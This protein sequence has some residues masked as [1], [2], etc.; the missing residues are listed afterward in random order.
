MSLVPMSR[1]ANGLGSNGN[2]INVQL[3]LFQVSM[4]PSKE[5]FH[6]NVEIFSSKDTSP[7]IAMKKRIFNYI[8]SKF[9]EALD[10]IGPIFD[11]DK[12]VYSHRELQSLE[13]T[14]KVPSFKL[15][16]EDEEFKYILSPVEKPK[17]RTSDIFHLLFGP[18][19]PSMR[20]KSDDE[21]GAL[22]NS[23][24]RAM[25]ALNVAVRYLLASNCPSTSR[26]FFPDGAPFLDIGTGVILRR[27][28]ITHM[29]MGNTTNFNPPPD[30]LFLAM[31]M[32]CATFL[33]A[34]P[35]NNPANT[36]AD[37]CCKI[38]NIPPQRMCNLQ[39]DDYRKLHK[40]LRRFKIDIVRGESDRGI[41]KSI[42]HLT[43][44]NSR[45]EIF[46]TDEGETSVEAFFLKT[47]G[48]RLRFPDLPNVVTVGKGKKTVY[49]M[50]LCSIRKGQRYILKLNG[51]QQSSALRFQTIKP[52]GRF[53]QIMVARE[54]V[55]DHTHEKLLSAYGIKIGRKFVEAQ[56]RVLPPPV[57]EYSQNLR[58]SVR[59]GQWNIAKP[60]LQLLSTKVLKSWAVVICTSAHLPEQALMNFLG[61][62]RA[63]LIQLGVQVADAPPPIIRLQAPGQQPQVKEALEKAGK[64]A[65]QSFDKNP[66][67]LFLCITDERSYLYNPIKVE[68]DNFANRGVTTQCM[69]LKHV[70]N[71]KDQYLSNLALKINLKIGGLNHR[72]S[73]L[74]PACGGVPTMIVGADLT[75]N[76]L[77]LKMKPSIAALVGSLD[78]T[79]LKFAPAVGVQP[80]LEPSDEDGR[81]RSQE[82]IQLFRTLL[83]NLLQ[84]WGKTNPGPKFPRRMIIFRDGVSDGEFSQVL[85]SE[86]KAAKA[87]I[88][89]I[90][91]KPDQCKIT[92]IVCVK[93]HRLRMSP[94]QRCQDRSGNAPA[95]SVLDNRIGDPFLFDFFAQTQAGLQGTSRPTRYVILKDESNSS[96]DDLQAIIQIISSGFQRAT[97]SV[98]LAT[99]AY[100]ADIVASRAKMWVN[101]DDDGASTV[102]SASSGRDQT[103]EDRARDLEVYQHKI[104]AMMTKMDALDQQMWWI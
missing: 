29:R 49:P 17:W 50:E 64:T 72:L 79:L 73:D 36:L 51:D 34:P 58:I 7:P 95:G 101:V 92:Y 104:N 41:T 67:Q 39:E 61:G 63:K 60:N 10:G 78:R 100:Y 59:D 71:A 19:G 4:A 12:T 87:A 76:N 44:T 35:A 8:H 85:E 54:H 70:K 69:V 40:M 52:E 56:A 37:L 83:S 25:Q 62:L 22:I 47:W 98:G 93:N 103:A 23:S 32:T 65:W 45:S 57:V 9:G 80:L 24:R 38:L 82:P 21:K 28:Y 77:S 68:G 20:N 102:A 6:Y 27:G 53:Q 96:A 81:P 75:H 86:F 88:E 46:Q 55:M 18:Q 11:G 97:R 89:K 74:E 66:P 3:N 91:G 2:L 43:L 84:K 1:P 14:V 99:P 94:D 90:A 48:R 26:A 16:P 33:E 13:G 31:D 15:P 42:D 5:M 30:N